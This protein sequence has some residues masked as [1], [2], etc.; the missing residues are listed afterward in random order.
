MRT[1]S[2][3]DE[4][5]EIVKRLNKEMEAANGLLEKSEAAIVQL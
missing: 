3:R 4:L 1:I 2:E 5:E